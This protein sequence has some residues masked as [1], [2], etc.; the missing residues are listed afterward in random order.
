M[1]G[2]RIGL[3]IIGLAIFIAVVGVTIKW[4]PDAGAAAL[5]GLVCGI[6]LNFYLQ[7]VW[8]APSKP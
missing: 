3:A 8:R 7:L 6:A 1:S 2:L 4:L 5:V